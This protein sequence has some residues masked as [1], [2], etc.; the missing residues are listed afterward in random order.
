MS[1]VRITQCEKILAH[2]KK[3]GSITDLEA[4]EMYSVRRL[5]GRIFEL[6][7]RFNI[8]TEYTTKPNRYGQKV[9]FATYV[10]ED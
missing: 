9:T 1:K 3:Y 2:L 4:Y 7:S 10:L 8:R 6:R 5:S